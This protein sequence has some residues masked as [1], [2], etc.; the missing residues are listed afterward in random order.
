MEPGVAVHELI[1]VARIDS[2][3]V[4]HLR[5]VKV[6]RDA[7]AL[8]RVDVVA[9]GPQVAGGH[10]ALYL[11]DDGDLTEFLRCQAGCRQG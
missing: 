1:E 7:P 11:R 2:E 9:D 4:D 6:A 10:A 8:H 5:G 3:D